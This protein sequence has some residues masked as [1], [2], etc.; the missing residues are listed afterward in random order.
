MKR[1]TF[2]QIKKLINTNV[3]R[4]GETQ[5]VVDRV[6]T[7]KYDECIITN[8]HKYTND[9][10]LDVE[11]IKDLSRYNISF[12]QI[13]HID[14]MDVKNFL[15]C[16]N[17]SENPIFEVYEKTD[18]LNEIIGKDSVIIDDKEL[19]DGMKIMLKNDVSPK[20]CNK[21]FRVKLIDDKIT[22]ASN[23]GRPKK[24]G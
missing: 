2:N 14:G 20:F 11:K 5:V 18:A 4:K 10:Q 12:Q 22:L 8:I 21:I 15:A 17:V 19:K 24:N 7:N 23:R 1:L 9:I 6:S 3:V 13:T 16:Y